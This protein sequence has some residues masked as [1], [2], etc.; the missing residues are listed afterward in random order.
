MK[1]DL[2]K[3]PEHFLVHQHFIGNEQVF[4]VQ[5]QH[6]G[7]SWTKDTMIFRS[8]VWSASG[9][10]V[11][12]SFPKFFNL[13]EHPELTPVPNSLK[14][15]SLL[16]KLDGSTL[17]LSRYKGVTIKRTRGTVD[18]TKQDNGY[19]VDY[20]LEKYPKVKEILESAD[21]LSYSLIFEWTTPTNP[22]VINYGD[23]PDMVLIGIIFHD[24]YRLA[25]QAYLDIE[26]IALGV[27]RPQRYSFDTV[28]QMQ[29]SVAEF[30]G[31]EGLCLY[32]NN[33]QNILK[34]KGE[35][36]PRAHRFKSDVASVEKIVDL[37]F[38]MDCLD[39][40]SFI[41][42]ITNT[43]DYEIAQQCRGNVSNIC[44]AWK[45]V[46]VIVASMQEK[47]NSLSGMSR[48]EAA[49]V[50]LQAYSTTNRAS[51]VFALLDGKSLTTDQYKKLLFQCLKAK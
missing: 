2:S 25:T 14:A 9:E 46:K 41:E 49:G 26:A 12:A 47:A 8:S 23:E 17:I 6:I 33:D 20:L 42:F 24:T 5:P 32:F 45:E 15:T 35:W 19:E 51:M 27:K 18:V 28:E 36:Y 31:V 1:I 50:I 22:I 37:W 44:D 11:S 30:K 29:A 7:V 4:L 39:Y 16:Q 13:G 34:C 10:L 38:G 3:I 43:Y 48:K 21:T 40:Q